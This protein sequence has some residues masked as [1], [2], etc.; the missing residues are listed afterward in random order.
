M[1]NSSTDN[2]FI[3]KPAV[4][5][6]QLKRSCS[7]YWIDYKINTLENRAYVQILS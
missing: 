7:F 1:G 5:A 6:A 2:Y 3:E 4:A